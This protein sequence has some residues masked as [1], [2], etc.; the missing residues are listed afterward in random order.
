MLETFY[1]LVRKDM[2]TKEEV[3]QATQI[4]EYVEGRLERLRGSI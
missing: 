2:I 3:Q 4:L 1:N